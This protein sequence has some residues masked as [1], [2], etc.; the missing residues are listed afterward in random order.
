M[1]LGVFVGPVQAAGRSYLARAAPEALRGQMF[2]LLAFS[3]K[4]TAFVGPFLVGWV[5]AAFDSQRAG[6]SIIVVLLSLGFLLMLRVPET[7]AA[8]VA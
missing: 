7:A 5:T 4:A 8:R 3:G 1:L 6:M 2:G